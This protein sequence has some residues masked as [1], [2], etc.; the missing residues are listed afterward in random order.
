[1]MKMMN[2][3]DRRNFLIST[4][5][6]AGAAGVVPLPLWAAGKKL[7]PGKTSALIV[8]DVQNCFVTGLATDF[9]VAWTALDARKLGSRPMSSKTPAAAST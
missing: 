3:T 8:V 7:K 1:M 2:R 5:T 4:L 6:V 9:C